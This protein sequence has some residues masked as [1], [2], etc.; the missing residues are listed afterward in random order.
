LS[1]GDIEGEMQYLKMIISGAVA[2]C[3]I[4]G[5]GAASAADLPARTYTKAPV[6]VAPA[7]SWTGFYVG[8]DV[9]YGWGKSTGS[10]T[11][12]VF[13]SAV[14]YNIQPSGVLGGGFVGAN[15]QINQFVL[16]VEA[17]WQ[18]ADLRDRVDNL[19]GAYTVFSKVRDYGSVRGRLGIAFDRFLIFGTG[20]VAWGSWTTSFAGTNAPT[21]DTNNVSGHAGWTAGAGLE[22]A[23]TD[24][25]IGKAEYRYTDLGS[26]R[27]VNVS[28]N[29][30]DP[31]NRVTIN[32]VRLGISYKWGGPAVTR[33]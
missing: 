10:L 25:W 19:P 20:G 22:Y 21:F 3:A 4:A 14:P 1:L 11:T 15:Y 33:Y 26:V 29:S 13:S 32:D 17:D 6:M 2:I 5:I 12:N 18:A 24:N 8:A 23:F 27:H 7:F 9:G 16:G 28:A 30:G 31:G